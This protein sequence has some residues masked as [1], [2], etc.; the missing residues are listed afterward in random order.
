M[1]DWI[2]SNWQFRGNGFLVFIRTLSPDILVNGFLH[3]FRFL[4]QVRCGPVSQIKV[5]V[6]NPESLT[7]DEQKK[8]DS[9]DKALE[10]GTFA[11]AATAFSDD[12]ATADKEGCMIFMDRPVSLPSSAYSS[13]SRTS[14]LSDS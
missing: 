1:S 7:E 9:I 4:L 12:T 11:D 6:S 10:S 13:S 14:S 3:F 5:T 2:R 8:V